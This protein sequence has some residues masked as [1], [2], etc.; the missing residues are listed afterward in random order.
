MA[1][2]NSHRA[3]Q[4]PTPHC[5]KVDHQHTKAQPGNKDDHANH[6]VFKELVNQSPCPA[7]HH[8]HL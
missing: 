7:C 8:Q 6:T 3:H 5:V 2:N 4:A 1:L